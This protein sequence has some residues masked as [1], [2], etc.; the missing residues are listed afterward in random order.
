M[1]SANCKL[2]HDDL[3]PFERPPF[4]HRTCH[5]ISEMMAFMANCVA[6]FKFRSFSFEWMMLPLRLGF[7]SQVG[8]EHSPYT[9]ERSDIGCVLTFPPAVCWLV[10]PGLDKTMLENL[11]ACTAPR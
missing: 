8:G 10:R 7:P 2:Q 1:R 11:A 3:K 6:S 4:M 9:L 5:H